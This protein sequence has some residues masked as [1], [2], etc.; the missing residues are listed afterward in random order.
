[1]LKILPEMLLT[2]GQLIKA[3]MIVMRKPCRT[4]NLRDTNNIE[5]LSSMPILQKKRHD[6]AAVT[7]Y[8]LQ[9]I[10]SPQVQMR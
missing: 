1:M 6:N 8:I 7:F 5:Q 4:C 10:H 3:K 9:V 2:C